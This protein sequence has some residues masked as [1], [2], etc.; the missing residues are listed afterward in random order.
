MIKIKHH[1]QCK[2]RLPIILRTLETQRQGIRAVYFT[3]WEKTDISHQSR[4]VGTLIECQNQFLQP[5]FRPS[6]PSTLRDNGGK[7]FHIM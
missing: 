7:V 6:L 5:Q 2:S 1:I 4:M 3:T